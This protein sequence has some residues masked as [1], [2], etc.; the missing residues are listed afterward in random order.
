[1]QTLLDHDHAFSILD[2]LLDRSNRP[3]LLQIWFLQCNEKLSSQCICT[4]HL[5]LACLF[6]QSLLCIDASIRKWSFSS[7]PRS[8]V[9]FPTN[10]FSIYLVLAFIY[11]QINRSVTRSVNQSDKSYLANLSIHLPICPF[12]QFCRIMHLFHVL[13]QTRAK[14]YKHRKV[15]Y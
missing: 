8:L 3:W 10:Y 15:D 4:G 5:S 1:M 13:P 11:Q 14:H 6:M 7:C 9:Q 12:I 2:W